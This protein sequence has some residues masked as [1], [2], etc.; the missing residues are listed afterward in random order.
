MRIANRVLATR[1]RDFRRGGL[2]KPPPLVP[3]LLTLTQPGN[4]K[5]F[6]GYMDGG[7]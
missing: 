4:F 6:K 3:G 5:R 7:Q 1:E 2:P